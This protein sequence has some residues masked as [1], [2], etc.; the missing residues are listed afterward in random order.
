[1]KIAR[2]FSIHAA[3]WSAMMFP[4]VTIPSFAQQ[5]VAP[6]WYDPWAPDKPAAPP[7]RPEAKPKTI[8]K[9]DAAAVRKTK[10]VR[11]KTPDKAR[12]NEASAAADSA[13]AMIASK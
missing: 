7:V 4:L 3:L 13:P 11:A 9:M 1:M 2:R 5:E 10:A 12:N 6:T 8:H